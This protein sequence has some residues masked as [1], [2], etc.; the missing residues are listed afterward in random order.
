MFTHIKISLA[1][2]LLAAGVSAQAQLFEAGVFVGASNYEGDLSD[3]A[4]S[5]KEF[6]PAVGGIFRIN[7]DKFFS[8]KA[9]VY[10]GAISGSDHNSIYPYLRDRNLS[11]RSNIYEASLQAEIN[12]LGYKIRDKVFRFNPQALYQNRWVALQPLGTEG[13]NIPQ[14]ADRAYDLT[15]VALPLGI[16][17]KYKTFKNVHL[18]LEFGF[19]KTFTDYLDDVSTNYV[20]IQLLEENSGQVAA[21]LSDRSVEVLG[22]NKPKPDEQRGD[23]TDKDWYLFSGVNLTFSLNPAQR[24]KGI[25]CFEFK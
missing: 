16:G 20:D 25:N 11:F 13:Q 14:Y 15:Q 24:P 17:V 18:S 9:S 12:V 19:R 2:L 10:F 6:H 8:L 5:I 22:Y 1:G 21:A 4:F 3:V 7:P 23:P